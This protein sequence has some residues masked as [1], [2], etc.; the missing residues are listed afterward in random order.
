MCVYQRT[1]IKSQSTKKNKHRA[2]KIKPTSGFTR[3]N[4]QYKDMD[5]SIKHGNQKAK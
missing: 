3:W 5:Y 1:K 4:N 2:K